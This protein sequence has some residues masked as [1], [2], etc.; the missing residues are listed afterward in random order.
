VLQNP[1]LRQA[2]K[3]YIRQFIENRIQKYREKKWQDRVLFQSDFLGE[4]I[5]RKY[6]E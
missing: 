5:D 1:P 2:A 6:N 3:R 4:H